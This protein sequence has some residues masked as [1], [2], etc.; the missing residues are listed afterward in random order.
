MAGGLV[1]GDHQQAEVVV[2]LALGEDPL[3]LGH[4]ERGDHV[5]LRFLQSEVALTVGV[6]EHLERDGGAEGEVTVGLGVDPVDDGARELGVLV[7]D[8]RVAPLD[9]HGGVL[10]RHGEDR[11]QEPDR[12]LLRDLEREVELLHSERPVEHRVRHLADE[13]LVGADP[14][15]AEPLVA[16][17]PQLA[18]AGR[19][20]LEHRP[21]DP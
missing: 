7:P 9:Q 4:R 5:V 20:G 3:P 12:E 1:A 10:L 18:V 21:A 6:L 2:E 17:V 15:G 19:V 16:D 11:A 8:H 14:A 13:V